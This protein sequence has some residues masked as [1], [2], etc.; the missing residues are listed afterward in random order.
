VFD[1]QL[2]AQSRSFDRA[3]LDQYAPVIHE[4]GV[5]LAEGRREYPWLVDHDV[6]EVYTA[7]LATMKTFSSGLYY[8]TLPE[9]PARISV[10]RRLK[11]KLD[12]FITPP[13]PQHRALRTSEIL[14]ILDFLLLSVRI[15]SNGRPKSRRYLDWISEISG[16][17]PPSP[18]ASRLI[19]P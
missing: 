14:S 16:V 6:E 10:F 8:E 9:G 5:A 11:S 13:D 7:L 17:A 1:P 15:N 19:I 4:L 2:V 12:S 18:E 3:F